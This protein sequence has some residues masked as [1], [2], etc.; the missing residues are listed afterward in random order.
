MKSEIS[1]PVMYDSLKLKW[2][3]IRRCSLINGLT[4]QVSLYS[5]FIKESRIIR[6]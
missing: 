2:S 1:Q 4:S 5:T 6:Q 3:L